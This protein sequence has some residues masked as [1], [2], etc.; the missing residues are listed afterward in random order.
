MLLVGI[1]G[2]PAGGGRP[3][4]D[5]ATTLKWLMIVLG[6]LMLVVDVGLFAVMSYLNGERML[7]WYLGYLRL[8]VH[9]MLVD[10]LP[11]PKGFSFSDVITSNR[12]MEREP[13][14]PPF[15]AAHRVGEVVSAGEEMGSLVG[16]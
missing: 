5:D 8:G 14:P 11:R 13:L 2:I 12:G 3:G 4:T 9:L 16:R 1:I 6:S 15:A 10:V 7:V